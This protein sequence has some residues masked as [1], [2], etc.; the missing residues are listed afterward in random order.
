MHKILLLGS[1]KIGITIVRFLSQVKDYN[2]LVGDVDG[3]GEPD[4][5]GN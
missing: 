4:V 2:L 3:S 5:A 1:G